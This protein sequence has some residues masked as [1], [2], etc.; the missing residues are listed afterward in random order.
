VTLDPALS[1]QQDRCS[2]GG[3]PPLAIVESHPNPKVQMKKYVFGLSV[4]ALV[5]AA[6]IAFAA[7]KPADAAPAAKAPMYTAACP[8]PCSFS[9]SSHDKAEVVAVLQE[10]AKKGHNM[11][12]SD[13]DAEAMV[14]TKTP[15][16]KKQ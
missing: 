11:T 7:E 14:K 4:S 10:H 13:K 8:D 2:A 1:R 9:V 15:K 12:L 6:S 5:L 16:E 3:T